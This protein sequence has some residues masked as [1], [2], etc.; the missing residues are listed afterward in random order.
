[1]LSL[2]VI[3]DS[4]LKEKFQIFTP[5]NIVRQMLDLADYRHRLV[6]KKVLE[7]CCGNGNFL[8]QIVERYI[9]DAMREGFSKENIALGLEHDIVA[10]EIDK[11]LIE[12]C[13]KQLNNIAFKYGLRTI[14]WN[15]M[16]GDFLD[17]NICGQFDFI[18]G[19]P[20][21]IAYQDLPDNE[22]K[23]LKKTFSTCEKGKFDYSYAFI[24]K[25]FDMLAH[26]GKLVY[27][28][29]SNIF[30]NVYAEE[31]RKLI[32]NDLI[33][34]VDFPQDRVF[35]DVLVSPAIIVVEKDAKSDT[36]TYTKVVDK[37]ST[38]KC[39]SKDTL[40]DKWVF[41][42]INLTGK[43]VGS[44]FKVSN[45]IATL[46]N[47]VFVLKDGH[48]DANF[49][50]FG[51]NKIEASI[52]RKATSPKSKRYAQGRREFIIFPYRYNED[53]QLFHYEDKEFQE[54]FPYTVQ[55]LEKH[56]MELR[57]RDSDK[58]TKWFEYGRSQALQYM[59]QK[60]I[61]LSSVISEDTKAYLLSEG[62]I[63]YAGIYIIPTGEI[64]LESLLIELNSDN[65]KR[66]VSSVGVS[67]SGSSKR[68]TTK[69]IE[70]Y[71]F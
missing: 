43:K 37:K 63:P 53:G 33:T 52:L 14:H 58:S 61:M 7:N 50:Y 9:K 32:K 39:V 41:D 8:I 23:K 6:G 64:S 27:I 4:R 55:Y 54:K 22:R 34:V 56:K 3:S 20:P 19:N 12:Y 66:Y 25:S 69:D 11:E 47:R 5:T 49:F 62:E 68:I 48:F 29:P 71:E 2:S 26:R 31:L 28:I 67:V 46:C 18:I 30:K 42:I 44:Y 35:S 59:N 1:M 24:E 21:Y 45:S 36:M 57:E 40:I 65:F 60:M 70:N 15:I 38:T 16:W 17:E 51:E 10:Y 13:K